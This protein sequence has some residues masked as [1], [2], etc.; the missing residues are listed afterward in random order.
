MSSPKNINMKSS[1]PQNLHFHNTRL[2]IT[3]HIALHLWSSTIALVFAV[4]YFSACIVILP[5]FTNSLLSPPTCHCRTHLHRC[6]AVETD[7]LSPVVTRH[8]CSAL[9][10]YCPINPQFLTIQL[11]LCSL[12]MTDTALL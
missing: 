7:P 6:V 9:D 8:H 1:I 5:L 3:H 2:H 4:V 10:L 12:S 11:S